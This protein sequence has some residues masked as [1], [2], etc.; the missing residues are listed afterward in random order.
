LVD[1]LGIY[2]T[3]LVEQGRFFHLDWHLRRLGQSA[4]ILGMD[5]PASL[6][7]IGLW[8]RLLM[9]TTQDGTGLLRIVAYGSDG[10]HPAYCGLYLKPIPQWPQAAYQQG[11]WVI[12][13]PGERTRPL[14]KSTNCLAQALARMHAQRQGAIEGLL[15]DR[16]GH[17]TEGSTS[18][19]LA[20]RSGELL[21]PLPG[22]ALDGVTE[23]IVMQLATSLGIPV[24]SVSLPQAELPTWEEAFITSSTRRIM[25][26]RRVDE[27]I[28]PDTPGPVTRRL[29]AAYRQYESVQGWE[30]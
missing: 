30:E 25:P 10:V 2:E 5:L 15:V 17:I 8:A 23:A 12:T 28:L 4:Q 3:V 14:A 22:T 18:N 16:L 24:R 29:M 7:D 13:S 6:Q 21:R 9:A 27:A 19:I 11:I 1:S 20:V 26:V